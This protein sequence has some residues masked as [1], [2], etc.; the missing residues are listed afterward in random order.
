[1][2]ITMT[3]LAICLGIAASVP[4]NNLKKA[5]TYE[6]FTRL[7]SFSNLSCAGTMTFR[8][9]LLSVD[10]RQSLDA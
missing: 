6:T 7:C 8:L 2:G 3:L 4:K 5:W 1:M 10:S 9:P